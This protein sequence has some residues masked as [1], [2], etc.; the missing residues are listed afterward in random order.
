MDALSSVYY[1]EYRCVVKLLNFKIE[2]FIHH[3]CILLKYQ[4]NMIDLLA[5]C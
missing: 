3:V 4:R 2:Y 1:V 5:L